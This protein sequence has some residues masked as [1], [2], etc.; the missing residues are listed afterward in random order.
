MREGRRQD[1]NISMDDDQLIQMLKALGDPRRFRMV[2]ELAAAGELS[3][4]ELGRRFALSQATMSHHIK[5]LVDSGALTFRADGQNHFLSV[6]ALLL[7]T[8]GALLPQ[9]LARPAKAGKHRKVA[10]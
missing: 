4:G 2:Q 3:C 10:R 8:L 9:R 7:G 5:L 1:R 6:N